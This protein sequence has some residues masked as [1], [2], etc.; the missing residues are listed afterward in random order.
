MYSASEMAG[1][2]SG[3]PVAPVQPATPQDLAYAP[4]ADP[5]LPYGSSVEIELQR[6]AA[7]SGMD[8]GAAAEVGQ[9]WTKILSA[10][11]IPE[12]EVAQLISAGLLAASGLP[13]EATEAGWVRAA[14]ERINGDFGGPENG[15][16]ALERA[17]LYVKAHP[18]LHGFLARTGLGNHPRVVAAVAGVAHRAHRTGKLK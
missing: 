11:G 17:R 4:L 14:Q 18:A 10:H 16:R 12:P 1:D 6:A 9:S 15:A 3:P 2:E 7:A 13:D 8:E 5:V